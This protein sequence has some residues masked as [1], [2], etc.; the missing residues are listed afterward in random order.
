M[1]EEHGGLGAKFFYNS[2]NDKYYKLKIGI[3]QDLKQL[4]T[5]SGCGGSTQQH[6]F[7]CPYCACPNG[8]FAAPAPYR[9]TFCRKLDNDLEDA[10]STNASKRSTHQIRLLDACPVTESRTCHHHD[11]LDSVT[12]KRWEALRNELDFHGLIQIIFPNES[13]SSQGVGEWRS[14]GERLGIDEATEAAK[15]NT[16]KRVSAR[17]L[18]AKQWSQ[19]IKDWKKEFEIGYKNIDD[20]DLTSARVDKVCTSSK[21][22]LFP[23]AIF[24]SILLLVV[25]HLELAS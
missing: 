20:R 14:L 10:R 16:G 8:Q 15:L 21:F 18:N 25:R 11:F 22:I 23:R 17:T 12:R 4:M 7:P 1:L 6:Y 19:V 5:S 13:S 24:D 3:C 9:C 2:H